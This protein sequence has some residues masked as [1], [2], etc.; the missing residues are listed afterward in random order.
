MQRTGWNPGRRNRHV[1][2][3]AHGHG[4]DNRL[5]IPDGTRGQLDFT[6]QLRG[7]VQVYRPVRLR[8]LTFWVEPP[9]KGF[10][11]PC[12]VDDIAQLLNGLPADTLN[13]LGVVVLRQPTRKQC[14]LRPVWGRAVFAWRPPQ[15]VDTP[16]VVLD[17]QSLMP[18]RWP[19]S[20]G[21][22]D[23]QELNRLRADGHDVQP[24]RRGWRI[25]VTPQSL[26]ATMLNRTVLHE[27]GHLLDR[28][29]HSSGSWASKPPREREDFA[30]RHA[31]REWA[32]LNEQAWAPF[33]PIADE[34]QMQSEGL[35]PAWFRPT[36]R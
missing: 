12:T 5:V 33:A 29:R 25:A 17:A 19:R 22:E 15:G 20:L 36:C 21:M 7:A 24:D 8:D 10:F 1:G 28:Q 18:L 3:K 35:N 30:H 11:H 27:L 26:R 9:S 2:T 13:A 31:A 6:E 16:A 32:R 4:A 23:V 14:V 34:A